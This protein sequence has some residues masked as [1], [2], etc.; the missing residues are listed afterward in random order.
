MLCSNSF[1]Q[2]KALA[3]FFIFSHDNQHVSASGYNK[4]SKMSEENFTLQDTS[5]FPGEE[6]PLKRVL[7][8]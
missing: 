8:G 1:T 3:E 6:I 2:C 5:P 4:K 7:C